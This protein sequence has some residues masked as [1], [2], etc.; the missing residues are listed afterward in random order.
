MQG[1]VE[2]VEALVE[3]H[4]DI[5]QIGNSDVTPLHIAAMCGYYE[6]TQS[7][8]YQV[9]YCRMWSLTYLLNLF[10]RSFPY[11]I[12]NLNIDKCRHDCI[13]T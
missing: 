1:D 6:V 10:K 8:C 4:A 2:I 7:L 9:E 5:N 11:I 12:L 3:G 13:L